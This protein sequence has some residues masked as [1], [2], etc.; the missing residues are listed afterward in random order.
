MASTDV[1]KRAVLLSVVA[2]ALLFSAPALAAAAGLPADSEDPTVQADAAAAYSAFYGVPVN[3]AYGRL[4][5]QDAVSSVLPH[6]ANVLGP[7]Y[8]GAWFDATDNGRLKLGVAASLASSAVSRAHSLL[9]GAGVDTYTDFV[10][11]PRSLT[12]LQADHA[13]IDQKL[14]K[15][16]RSGL[17]ETYV[18]VQRN[19]IEIDVAASATSADTTAIDQ[20]AAVA[21]SSEPVDV[22]SSSQF[23]FHLQNQS[24]AFP[25][26]VLACDP[27]LRGGTNLISANGDEFCSQGLLVFSNANRAPYVLTAGHCAEADGGTGFNSEFAD[28]NPHFIGHVHHACYQGGGDSCSGDEAIITIDNPTGWQAS[29]CTTYVWVGPSLGGGTTQNSFYVINDDQYPTAGQ[30]VCMTAGYPTNDGYHTDCGPVKS[31]YHSFMGDQN[32]FQAQLY[33]TTTG[34]DSGGPYYKD[35]HFYGT[36]VGFDGTYEYFEPAPTEFSVLNVF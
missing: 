36:H 20:A 8:G 25:Y 28:G 29:C 9:S 10:Q 15:Q 22:Q 1:V 12:E 2:C 33:E 31:G 26:S 3:V 5:I 21:R 7:A 35:G 13:V 32:L 34:G 14:S 6:V 11:V 19:A 30:I 16:L 27:P 18:D 23:V 4:Q 17:V 24:C